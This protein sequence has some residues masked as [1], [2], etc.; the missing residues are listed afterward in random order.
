M[1]WGAV[2][3]TDEG[4]ETVGKPIKLVLSMRVAHGTKTPVFIE[5]QT[6]AT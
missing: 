4:R 3:Y 5:G 6:M 1:G 2:V